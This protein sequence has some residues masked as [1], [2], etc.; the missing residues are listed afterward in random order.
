MYLSANWMWCFT[1]N[2]MTKVLV[3]RTHCKVLGAT[4]GG[5]PVVIAKTDIVIIITMDW[6]KYD[7]SN[8]CALRLTHPHLYPEPAP[9]HL[10]QRGI[11]ISGGGG[12]TLCAEER[13]FRMGSIQ[14][15]IA[16]SCWRSLKCAIAFLCAL[17]NRFHFHFRNWSHSRRKREE[18]KGG[19]LTRLGGH[20]PQKTPYVYIYI[21][22][23][24]YI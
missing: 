21:Y 13:G 15:V 4:N 1:F 11:F 6:T 19:T 22:I 2:C 9:G 14:S 17:F 3:C 16:R 8:R 5:F 7:M 12:V 18:G 23:Y 20:G 24:I 10:H